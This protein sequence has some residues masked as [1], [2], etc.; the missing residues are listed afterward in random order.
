MPVGECLNEAFYS[1]ST[2]VWIEACTETNLKCYGIKQKTENIIRNRWLT[3][4]IFR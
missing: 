3:F 1:A 4:H 2:N